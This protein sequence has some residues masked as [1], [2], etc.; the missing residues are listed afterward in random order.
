M[1]GLLIWKLVSSGTVLFAERG[2][3]RALSNTWTAITINS[4][5]KESRFILAVHSR[6]CSLRLCGFGVARANPN[7]LWMIMLSTASLAPQIE[8]SASRTIGS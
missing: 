8:S 4:A 3:R 7:I 1:Q 2:R 6:A 5:L